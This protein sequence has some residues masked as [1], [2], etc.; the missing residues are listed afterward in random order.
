V[1]KTLPLEKAGAWTLTAEYKES[2]PELAR[3]LPKK[4]ALV[5]SSGFVVDVCSPF[6]GRS[7]K[8]SVSDSLFVILGYQLPEPISVLSVLQL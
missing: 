6:E 4:E 2:R 7:P 8:L 3:A 1:F 5:R